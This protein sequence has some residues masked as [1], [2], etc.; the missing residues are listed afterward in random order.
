MQVERKCVNGGPFECSVRCRAVRCS[1]RDIVGLTDGDRYFYLSHEP[2]TL[3]RL[4]DEMRDIKFRVWDK[5]KK[6]IFY[7]VDCVSVSLGGGLILN[8]Q[9]D[10]SDVSEFYELMQYTGLKDKNGR[11]I[12]EGDIV[13]HQSG[14][15]TQIGKGFSVVEWCECGWFYRWYQIE[16]E[17]TETGEIEAAGWKYTKMYDSDG[18][19]DIIGNIYENP[20]MLK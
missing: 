16:H 11:E 2:P 9:E 18:C 10:E 1:Y 6:K 17:N 14:F 5:Q 7:D 15:I 8:F 12:Y 20:E 19:D 3:L 4:E 13:R